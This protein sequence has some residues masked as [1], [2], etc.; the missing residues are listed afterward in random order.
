MRFLKLPVKTFF[1]PR[2]G[3]SLGNIYF[4]VRAGQILGCLL[5]GFWGLFPF[6]FSGFLSSL[7]FL[8]FLFFFQKLCQAFV[9]HIFVQKVFP[10]L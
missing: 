10:V 9:L 3:N 4:S 2:R 6:V 1:R 7:F 8:R 5:F